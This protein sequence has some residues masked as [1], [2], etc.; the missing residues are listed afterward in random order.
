MLFKKP[1]QQADLESFV[2]Y[3]S[4]SK[5]YGLPMLEKNSEVIVREIAT[6]FRKPEQQQSNSLFINAEDY[7]IFRNGTYTRQT[8]LFTPTPLE[9]VIN[10]HDIRAQIPKIA[11][12][13]PDQGIVST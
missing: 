13:Q 2:I 11:S 7:S 1:E 6:T 12:Q 3:D 10:L 8:G 9:H 5:S 4:K